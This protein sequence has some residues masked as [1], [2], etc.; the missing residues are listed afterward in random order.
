MF[1]FIRINLFLGVFEPRRG[2][3]AIWDREFLS[4]NYLHLRQLTQPDLAKK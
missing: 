1:F 4:D 2:E 3:P